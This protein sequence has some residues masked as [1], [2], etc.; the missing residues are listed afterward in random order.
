MLQI[1][2]LPQ[3]SPSQHFLVYVFASFQF[4]LSFLGKIFVTAWWATHTHLQLTKMLVLRASNL[5]QIT[6]LLCLTRF[7]KAFVSFGFISHHLHRIR[8]LCFYPSWVFSFIV[9]ISHS[10]DLLHLSVQEMLGV[11]GFVWFKV[12]VFSSIYPAHFCDYLN[13]SLLLICLVSCSSS[14]V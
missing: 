9:K 6:N 3:Y 12:L 8:E 7:I 2:S 1:S 11:E 13:F 5:H 4:R 10:R 14:V